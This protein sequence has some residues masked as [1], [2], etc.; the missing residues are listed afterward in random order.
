MVISRACIVHSADQPHGSVTLLYF[1]F[2]PSSY[3]IR[4]LMK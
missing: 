3:S 2:V 1:M 4:A